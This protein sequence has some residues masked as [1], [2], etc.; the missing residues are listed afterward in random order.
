MNPLRNRQLLRLFHASIAATLLLLSQSLPSMA[1]TPSMNILLIVSDDLRASVLRCYGDKVC[2]TP[3]IDRLA[4][5]GM[6]FDRAYCQATHCAPSRASFM[7]GRYHGKKEITFGE[8]FIQSGGHSARVGKIFHMRVPG[9]IIAGSNGDDVGACWSER[10]NSAGQEAHTPGDYACLNLNIFT[11]ELEDRQSTGMPH[12]PFVSVRYGGGGADQ[13]DWK[14]AAKASELLDSYATSKKPF[15]LATGFVRPHYPSV[16]P[17]KYFAMYPHANIELPPV[18]DG[19]L[20]DIPDAGI[21]KSNSK[22]TG[23]AEYPE[24]Q[25]R[26]WAAYYATS[27]RSTDMHL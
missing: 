22:S 6:V 15:F 2:Q 10:Y 14:T 16:A 9:D 18:P 27:S 20:A 26:M 5:K 25:K 24:N 19:D 23:L 13:P 11:T 17:E 1:V 8:H 3:N 4:S 7:R 12:R 21:S